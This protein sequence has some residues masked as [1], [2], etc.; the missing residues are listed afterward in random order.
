[1]K[2][3]AMTWPEVAALDRDRTLVVA[4]IASCE[5]HGEHLP[6]FTDSILCGAVADGLEAALPK[7]TLLLP[8][9]WLGASDHHLPFGATVSARVERHVDLVADIVESV[10]SDGFRRVFVLNGHGG[11]VDTMHVALRRLQPRR[12]DRLFAAASYWDLADR[13]FAALAAGP[14]KTMGHACEM[15][16]SL[17]LHLRPDLVRLDRIADDGRGDSPALRGVHVAR[18]FSQLSAKGPIGHP[19]AASAETGKALL[20]AAVRRA[21][22]A[23]LALLAAPIELTRARTD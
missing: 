22:D 9:Q 11:N 1:M 8:V 13:E 23:A 10:A 12:P 17:M 7:R 15:E 6:A 20:E 4:P 16:T 18:D 21:V 19:T 5:Q 2:L 3:E 14:R